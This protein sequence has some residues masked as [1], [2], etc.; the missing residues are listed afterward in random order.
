MSKPSP[1]A[2]APAPRLSEDQVVDYLRRHLTAVHQAL[3]AGADVRGYLAWSLMD[4]FE[5]AL[6]YDKRFGLVAVDANL[7]RV[8]KASADWYGHV[9]RTA[10]LPD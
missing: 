3:E 2:S 10:T 1:F 4:N 8:P 9:A 7:R 6:G 5:W